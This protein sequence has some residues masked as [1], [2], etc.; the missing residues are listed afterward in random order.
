MECPGCGKVHLRYV[1]WFPIRPKLEIYTHK[2]TE[3]VPSNVVYSKYWSC[4]WCNK[5]WFP[6]NTEYKENA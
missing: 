6:D 1:T 5:L 3:A 4:A 2:G